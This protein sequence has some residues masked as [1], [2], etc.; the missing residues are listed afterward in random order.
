RQVSFGAV[1][2]GRGQ[3]LVWKGAA[4]R[5]IV[6][7]TTGLQ[8]RSRARSGAE[9]GDDAE[10]RIDGTQELLAGERL[11]QEQS[12]PFHVLADRSHRVPVRDEDRSSRELASNLL[13]RAVEDPPVEAGQEDVE[14]QEIVMV[15]ADVLERRR[16][17]LGAVHLEP[18]TGEQV[19]NDAPRNGVVID[20]EHALAVADARE[21]SAG[22]R[23]QARI[24][25]R[26]RLGVLRW[27]RHSY[28]GQSNHWRRG[29][30]AR[31]AGVSAVSPSRGS[32]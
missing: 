31:R 4:G 26:G 23:P 11:L 17:T 5:S 8:R 16:S 21:P 15:A 13:D 32:G 12:V 3:T 24:E 29:G 19:P 30:K 10:D 18:A 22:S 14:D 28:T 2:W 25:L 1:R 9:P 6:R 27:S 20:H 7:I